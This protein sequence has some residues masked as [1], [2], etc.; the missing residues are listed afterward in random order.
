MS[1]PA[2][3]LRA[4]L[5]GFAAVG[6]EQD[7]EVRGLR[8]D[9]RRVEPGDLF[10]A[11]PGETSD[12]REHIAEALRN[13][14]VAVARQSEANAD[15]QAALRQSDAP[16]FEIVDLKQRIGAIAARFF[17]HPSANMQV[18]G[19]TGTNGKTTCA[20]LLAQAL[21]R[22]GHRCALLGTLGAGFVG[23]L[24]PAALTTSDAIATHR[25]LARLRAQGADAACIEASSHGLDQGRVNEVAFDT[26]LL[27]NF[28]QDHLDYHRSMLRYGRA[29]LRLFRCDGL[30][31][32]V[33]NADDPFGRW[34]LRRLG[35]VQTLTYG[36]RDGAV[37]AR[38]IESRAS[39]AHR[40][41]GIEF[42]VAYQERAATVRSPLIGAFNVCNLLAVIAV[43]LAGGHDLARI[44]G[45]IGECAPPPGRMEWLPSS[46]TQPAVVIDYAH[47][48]DA[49]RR[50]LAA[51]RE[52]GGQ[53]SGQKVWAVF[54][55]GGE[56]DCDKRPRM[57]RVAEALAGRV[58]LTDDNPRFEDP[59][60][61]V[62]QV[63]RGMER[64]AR[65]IHDRRRAIETAIAEADAGD[66]VLIAGKG[67]ETTQ[68]IGADARAFNDRDIAAAVLAATSGA[69]ASGAQGSEAR[70]DRTQ[71]D[72]A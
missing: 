53:H 24:R 46:P 34:L 61:I 67:H 4:L 58:V 55:C 70:A 38:G 30:R 18:I 31:H 22:L 52:L 54:G 66:I 65:V 23:A 16:S 35:R 57:G 8:L 11:V 13:G 69:R 49:L 71:V 48:P 40:R 6:A 60:R 17:D 56:R 39:D 27:T 32:A 19:V 10:I 15:A 50:A 42:E 1:A 59:A 41:R 5:D 25:A 36:I 26:A 28:S 7:R 14:A 44:V 3:S 47:T 62:A 33:I 37:R 64:E 43:L 51:L 9:S 63:A 68:T 12:G 29:K 45:V 72:R 20:Y 21:D 2:K